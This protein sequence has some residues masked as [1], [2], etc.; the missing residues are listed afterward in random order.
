MNTNASLQAIKEAL[1][2][3]SRNA[4]T[5]RF[6]PSDGRLISDALVTIGDLQT[7]IQEESPSDYMTMGT[8]ELSAFRRLRKTL[9]L[10][11]NNGL[12][13]VLGRAC[14]RIARLNTMASVMYQSPEF[15]I[16]IAARERIVGQFEVWI[17]YDE[18]TNGCRGMSNLEV[19]QMRDAWVAAATKYQSLPRP[20]T[21]SEVV[22]LSYQHNIKS[23]G[24]HGPE[25]LTFDQM[26]AFTHNIIKLAAS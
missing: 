14:L 25:E 8:H 22:G 15:N 18:Q 4:S 6:M 9:D 16:D 24:G 5:G 17:A 3:L 11:D 23:I 20:L 7:A 2:L 26:K 12:I 10:S 1:I 13:D 21:D 19:D